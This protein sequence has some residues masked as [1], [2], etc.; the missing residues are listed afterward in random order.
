MLVVYFRTLWET[1]HYRFFPFAIAA[2]ALLV[3]SRSD[4]RLHPPRNLLAWLLTFASFGLAVFGTLS[5]SPW[6]VALG[7]FAILTCCFAEMSGPLDSSL[8]M[9][10]L[11]IWTTLRLPF[12]LNDA[13]VAELQTVTTR[14]SSVALDVIS[15]PHASMGN[16]LMLADRELFVAEA[17]SGAQS[18]FSI[19]FIACVLITVRRL[20]V[21]MLSIYLVTAVFLAVTANVIRVTTI[22]WA[23]TAID[24]DLSNDWP[25]ELLGYFCL[26]IAIGFFISFDQL[27]QFLFHVMGFDEKLGSQNPFL[28]FW[29]VLAV[30]PD[31]ISQS[32]RFD[33]SALQIRTPVISRALSSPGFRWSF[34]GITF[35]VAVFS[36]VQTLKKREQGLAV[37]SEKLLFE[38]SP[39][40][41]SNQKGY[42]SVVEHEISRGGRDARLGANADVW[43]CD[44][45]DG[46]VSA[47]FV[48]SQ[49]YKG[50]KELC[51]CYE[52]REWELV[53]RTIHGGETDRAGDE[54][55]IVEK[56]ALGRFRNSQGLNAYLLFSAI[57][58]DGSIMDPLSR[59]GVFLAPRFNFGETWESDDV[60]MFQL[61][62]VAESSLKPSKLA[63]VKK[64]FV[65]FRSTVADAMKNQN[66]AQ[67]NIE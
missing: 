24:V 41:A 13:V 17:C 34:V 54:T 36:A 63:T 11:P 7:V 31:V 53:D 64:E 43:R 22:A 67:I 27:A 55:P 9:A 25:H 50:W 28:A 65:S 47:Q 48:L 60:V 39:N 8:A 33:T 16:V 1:E 26:A 51:V 19:G 61:W 37:S 30:D 23:A 4:G 58:Q 6:L 15:I 42:L 20:P 40:L 5:S 46:G 18:V 44:I 2:S 66:Q 56:Y 32:T 12:S 10:A 59:F 35:L 3:F 29:S 62:I 21:W 49:S 45:Q 14:L 52:A 38:P 57:R